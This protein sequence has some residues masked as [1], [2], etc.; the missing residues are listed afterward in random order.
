MKESG[1]RRW[2]MLADPRHRLPVVAGMALL[3]AGCNTQMVRPD[4]AGDFS[5][6]GDEEAALAYSTAFPVAS[7]REAVLRGDAALARG[8]LDRALFEYIRGLEREGADADL[9]YKVGRIHVDRQDYGR[10]ELAFSLALREDPD[11]VG[12]L[13]EAGI[14]RIRRRQ[15]EKAKQM[16]E[17]ALSAKSALP[18]AHNALGVIADL[19]GDFSAAQAHYEEAIALGGPSARC[20]NN[21]GYSRYLAGDLAGAVPAL[22]RSLKADPNYRRAW[23]N[24]ALVYVKQ[25]RYD[26]A[27]EAFARTEKMYK[28]FNDVGYIAMIAGRRDKAR[29]FFEEA[30][31]LSPT[32]YELADRNVRRLEIRRDDG[33][34]A[35]EAL[36]AR[37]RQR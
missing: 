36:G 31:R 17:R 9:L 22:E 24:L 4:Q 23:R 15:Y 25:G 34:G 18:R 28:A 12:A 29:H 8:D 35:Q 27:L 6:L 10:A 7:A 16:L 13:V 37:G 21:L 19:Q 30:M 26:E 2:R 32:Y 11:H 3:L 1:R 5:P 20:L 33:P 14:L